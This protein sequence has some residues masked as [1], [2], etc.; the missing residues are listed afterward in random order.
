LH[1]AWNPCASA[2]RG[3]LECY[4]VRW[5]IPDVTGRN[6]REPLGGLS[7][8]SSRSCLRSRNPRVGS[9]TRAKPSAA[10]RLA[11]RYCTRSASTAMPYWIEEKSTKADRTKK[12]ELF[13]SVEKKGKCFRSI[14][15][16]ICRPGK[17]L[18][19]LMFRVLA[20]STC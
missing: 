4:F 9:S 3:L 5:W 19:G 7:G 13:Q 6:G 8:S 16:I 2:L 15:P 11:P 18:G 10:L 1:K 12:P 14:A 20:E 17:W